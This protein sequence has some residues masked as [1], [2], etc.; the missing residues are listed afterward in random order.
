MI[1]AKLHGFT[2]LQLQESIE[3]NEQLC[4]PLQLMTCDIYMHAVFNTQVTTY[5]LVEKVQEASLYM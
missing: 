4:V 1:V 3:S 2:D 5:R